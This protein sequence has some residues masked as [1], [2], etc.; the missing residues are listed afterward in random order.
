M[1]SLVRLVAPL[2]AATAIVIAGSSSALAAASPSTASL[3]AAWCF[4]DIGTVYCFD[5]DGQV[6]YLDNHVGSSVSIHS[7]T[8]TTVTEAGAVVGE[9]FNVDY[10]RGVFKADGTVE[11]TSIVNTT[12]QNGD[13]SCK[14]QLVLRLVDYEAQV[15]SERSTC[16]A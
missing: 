4:D 1:R 7:R 9:S 5:V 3:D 6:Q 16:G 2:L 14:Y 11:M 10:F 8:K 15:F 13:T 12:S